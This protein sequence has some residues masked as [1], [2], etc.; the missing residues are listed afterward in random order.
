M[1]LGRFTSTQATS[2]RTGG[3]NMDM[4]RRALDGGT[5]TITLPESLPTTGAISHMVF[6]SGSRTA[7]FEA[8][9]LEFADEVA[10]WLRVQW[11]AEYDWSG[12]VLRLATEI[13]GARVTQLAGWFGSQ[14]SLKTTINYIDREGMISIL[15]AVS[16]TEMTEGVIVSQLTDSIVFSVRGY[17]PSVTER[18]EDVGS[19]EVFPLVKEVVN[20]LPEWSG[21]PVKGG[22]LFLDRGEEVSIFTLVG[23]SAMARLVKPAIDDGVAESLTDLFSEVSV[24]W[25]TAASVRHAEF[26]Q[27]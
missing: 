1:G 3:I 18:L 22:E 26:S 13:S 25:Q 17:P 11:D 8:G 12:G 15:E 7:E 23:E 21:T 20:R 27:V 5:V 16:V 10:A 2:T 14:H 24:S 6:R 9:P 4:I 19:F